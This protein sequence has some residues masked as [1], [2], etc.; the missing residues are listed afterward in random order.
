[1]ILSDPE[2]FGQVLVEFVKVGGELS[3]TEGGYIML[4]VDIKGW[5]V[6]LIGKEGRYTGG[7]VWR[8]VIGKFSKQEEVSPIVLLVQA[9]VSEVLFQGFV[10]LVGLTISLWIISQCEVEPDAE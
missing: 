5:V 2:R 10:S 7:G 4:R 9:R 6:A 8:I 1:M 3:S